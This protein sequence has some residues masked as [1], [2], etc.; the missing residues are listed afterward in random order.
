MRHFPQDEQALLARRLLQGKNVSVA[1][2]RILE[3]ILLSTDPSAQVLLSQAYSREL[4][5]SNSS[6]G[7]KSVSFP[8][9][10][11]CLPI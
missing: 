8:K 5:R 10:I 2:V 11:R 3:G 1:T 7:T 4:R 9:V 6:G